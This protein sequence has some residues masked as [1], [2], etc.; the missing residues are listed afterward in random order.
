MT[1]RVPARWRR[2]VLAS[3]LCLLGGGCAILPSHFHNDANEDK[4]AKLV[5][6][7]SKINEATPAR[8]KAMLSNVE[9]FRVEEEKLLT[10]LAQNYHKSLITA[11]P[12]LT[13]GEMKKRIAHD[14]KAIEQFDLL[15]AKEASDYL[16]KNTAATASLGSAKEAIVE[17]GKQIEAAKKDITRWNRS[18]ALMRDGFASLP[19]SLK[20][21]NA[22]G[23]LKGLQDAASAAGST[24]ITYMNAEGEEMTEKLSAILGDEAKRVGGNW[25]GGKKGEPAVLPDAPGITLTILNLGL[26][27]AQLERTRAEGRLAELHRRAIVCEDALAEMNLARQ[28]LSEAEAGLG[29]AA[30]DTDRPFKRLVDEW[31]AAKENIGK[32][33]GKERDATASSKLLSGNDTV[34]EELK[35]L[36]LLAHAELAIAR[37]QAVLPVTLARMKHEESITLSATMERKHQALIHRGLEGLAA[38]HK[39]GFT[40]EDAVKIIQIAQAVAVGAIARN[41]R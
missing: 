1:P 19:E 3:T 22:K 26:D 29:G 13:H 14:R 9:R 35:T 16:R 6:A 8:T 37:G 18:V 33:V 12:S 24:E 30:A 27:L 21:R 41:T 10:E 15:I 17:F 11:L 23:S 28:L 25:F 38:Y 20:T 4:S 40:K 5:T 36:R 2:G 34:A 7:M 31:S 39:A 32:L